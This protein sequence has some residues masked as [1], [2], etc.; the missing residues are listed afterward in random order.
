MDNTAA[1]SKRHDDVEKSVA[2]IK[3]KTAQLAS[4]AKSLVSTASVD[5]SVVATRQESIDQLTSDL[6]MASER[7]RANLGAAME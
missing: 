4:A 1:L 2:V 6:V 7:R 5:T 3:E